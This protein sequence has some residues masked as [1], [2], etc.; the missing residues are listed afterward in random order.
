MNDIG[1]PSYSHLIGNNA[2]IK[3]IMAI[4]DYISRWKKEVDAMEAT[5]PDD[6]S[7]TNQLAT[8]S[9]VATNS[10]TFQGNYNL[11]TDLSLPTTA[12]HSDIE[13]A[14]GTA[15]T[16]ADNNDYC[17]VDIP[18][19]EQTPD[20]LARSERYKYNGNSSAWGYEFTPSMG[21]T[22][23]Q[24][25]AI[26][27]GITEYLVGT[28]T[29]KDVYIG[30]GATPGDVMIEANHHDDL[31]KGRKIPVTSS[32]QLLW[33]ILPTGNEPSV[34]MEGICVPMVDDGTVTVD[35]VTYY[36]LKSK[37]TY[38]AAFSVFLL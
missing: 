23:E 31:F 12:T 9:S 18:T 36:V 35:D 34:F 29:Y 37:V 1:V 33:V 16:G 4:S 14:L 26:N 8:E 3:A 6:A 17:W 20:E 13:A 38:T 27:S 30:A 7:P 25:A 19:S 32:N 11:V 21:F 28:L 2:Q 15:V 24:W 22:Q 5:V 10:A